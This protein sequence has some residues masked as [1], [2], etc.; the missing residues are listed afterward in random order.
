MKLSSI[1]T[2]FY[3]ENSGGEAIINNT[4]KFFDINIGCAGLAL[5]T[6]SPVFEPFAQSS[7]TV[8]KQELDPALTGTI[9]QT[10]IA[11]PLFDEVGNAAGVFE[12]FNCEKAVFSVRPEEHTADIQSLR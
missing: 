6:K 2:M 4:T 1:S 3:S 5:S 9:V 7:Q 12:L 11:I 8:S 10:I